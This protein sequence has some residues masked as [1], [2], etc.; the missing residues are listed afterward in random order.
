M[1]SF[2]DYIIVEAEKPKKIVA[3]FGRMNPPT[4]GHGVLVKKLIDTAR[5]FKADH[6]IYLSKTHDAK[7]NPLDIKTKLKWAKKMFKG[8][9]ILGADDNLQTFIDMVKVLNTKYKILY[10]VAGSDRVAEYQK[11][12]NKYNGI[13]YNYTEI[14]VVS[15]GERDP[16]ADG[17]GGMSATK[18]REAA[19]RG[20]VN[21]FKSGLPQ[22]MH[23][24]A[25]K[26]MT[27][28]RTGM[29]L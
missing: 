23:K 19:A 14:V 21:S 25:M 3:A 13:E 12:L 28:V 24:D 11:L 17:A 22:H 18:M 8:V 4:I 6:V 26:I 7:K 1:K 5:E 2:K 10:L 20:D 9:N 27:D 16:D 29:K 15:A